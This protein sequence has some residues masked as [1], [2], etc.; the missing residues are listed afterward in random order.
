VK[1]KPD[2]TVSSDNGFKRMHLQEYLHILTDANALRHKGCM[3]GMMLAVQEPRYA[4][5]FSGPLLRVARRHFTPHYNRALGPLPA[6]KAQ[7]KKT[8]AKSLVGLVLKPT[9]FQPRAPTVRCVLR[10]TKK[11][12]HPDLA[13]FN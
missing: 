10:G 9:G 1:T 2:F 3:I 8:G 7:C 11:S 12:A 13:I 4:Y 5:G 6:G